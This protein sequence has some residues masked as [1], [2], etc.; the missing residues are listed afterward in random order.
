MPLAI[1]SAG[2]YLEKGSSSMLSLSYTA[3]LISCWGVS[4]GSP[5]GCDQSQQVPA[6]K[7][8]WSEAYKYAKTHNLQGVCS[9]AMFAAEHQGAGPDVRYT[10]ISQTFSL[11][12]AIIC[13]VVSTGDCEIEIRALC[14]NYQHEHRVTAPQTFCWNN[15]SKGWRGNSLNN[16][17]GEELTHLSLCPEADTGVSGGED[18]KTLALPT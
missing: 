4:L 3:K 12:Q 2:S 9:K 17:Q 15:H 18:Y 11:R 7:W 14:A 6:K 8:G 5:H 1:L 16:R 13:T 10:C